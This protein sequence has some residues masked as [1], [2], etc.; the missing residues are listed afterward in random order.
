MLPEYAAADD[1]GGDVNRFVCAA[2]PPA[3]VERVGVPVDDAVDDEVAALVIPRQ[4]AGV[5]VLPS[6]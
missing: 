2:A 5:G 3:A 4:E 6:L 1:D